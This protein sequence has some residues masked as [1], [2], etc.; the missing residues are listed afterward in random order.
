MKNSRLIC[1]ICGAALAAVMAA[2]PVSGCG[3]VDTY[4]PV[5]CT[6]AQD[7][8]ENG[9]EGSIK[10]RIE[11]SSKAHVGLYACIGGAVLVI[12]GMV[13]LIAVGK[14]K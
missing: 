8:E 1:T 9:G 5:I 7:N 12:A 3:M 4:D 14:R 13:C 10:Q 11:E 2:S 6:L